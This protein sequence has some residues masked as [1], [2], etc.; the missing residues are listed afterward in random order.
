MPNGVA[1]TPDGGRLYVANLN[2]GSVS[3]V[4]TASNT[5]VRTVAPSVAG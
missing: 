5:V 4:D 1:V 3:V 2:G